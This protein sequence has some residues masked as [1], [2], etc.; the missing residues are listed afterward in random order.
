MIK[1]G[2]Q[3]SLF[4]NMEEELVEKKSTNKN[5]KII[6]RQDDQ[7]QKILVDVHL[8]DNHPIN[9]VIYKNEEVENLKESIKLYG[10]FDSNIAC[11]KGTHARYTIL[12]GHR[13]VKAYRD[14]VDEKSIQ[15]KP[16]PITVYSFDSITEEN[17]FIIDMN[18]TSRD[19]DELDKLNEIY[20]M[21][22]A[23]KSADPKVTAQDITVL[24]AKRIGLGESQLKKYMR[25]FETF[26]YQLPEAQNALNLYRSINKWD[27]ARALEK[28]GIIRYEEVAS[29][30]NVAED[31][32]YFLTKK[33]TKKTINLIDQSTNYINKLS[34]NLD[35]LRKQSELSKKGSKQLSSMFK[36][37]EKIRINI[38]H[39]LD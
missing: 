32:N 35:E 3:E 6:V 5:K 14:L 26:D 7:A 36:S 21:S 22:V 19:R 2:T 31:Y 8:L 25:L 27:E 12:A 33:P 30:K 1:I 16:I 34:Q 24:L 10:F 13:R 15:N 39:Y 29:K 20:F 23:L 17:A 28:K 38:S 18:T 9:N 11:K 37:I 4:E